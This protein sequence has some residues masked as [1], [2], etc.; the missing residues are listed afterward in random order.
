M[1]K[2]P[3]FDEFEKVYYILLYYFTFACKNLIKHS[4]STANTVKVK[5][6]NKFGFGVC[7]NTSNLA[8]NIAKTKKKLVIKYDLKN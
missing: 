4:E 7:K 6:S 5:R 2:K 8:R 1:N 3:D